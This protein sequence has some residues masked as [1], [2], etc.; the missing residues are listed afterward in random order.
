MPR[1]SQPFVRDTFDPMPGARRMGDLLRY[2]AQN[3]GEYEMERGHYE[4]KPQREAQ[5]KLLTL[6]TEEAQAASD[7]RKALSKNDEAL[8]ALF[9]G[10]A[11]PD[12]KAIIRVV[13]PECGA[14]II[15]A[16]GTI[17]DAA[18]GDFTSE[19]VLRD[20]MRGIEATGDAFKPT[21]Y[22]TRSRTSKRL[23]SAL[24][25]RRS[26]TLS[27]ARWRATTASK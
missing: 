26:M 19:Q 3:A 18:R 5:A 2:R 13:G 8:A 15:T 6:Q 20:V 25:R 7:A 11:M 14:K 4:E 17:E 16:L 9:D 1:I 12:P 10:G 21:V 22:K 24:M 23:A 27:G